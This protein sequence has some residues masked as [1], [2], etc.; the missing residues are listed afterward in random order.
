MDV[1]STENQKYPK[2]GKKKYIKK[3][4]MNSNEIVFFEKLK[5]GLIGLHVFPQVSMNQVLDV[6]Q[7]KDYK[8]RIPFWAK[9]ID[10]VICTPQCQVL[11]IIELDGPS[12]DTPEQK[13]KDKDR[14]AML[15]QAGYIVLRYD[16][17]VEVTEHQL[18]KDFQRIIKVWHTIKLREEF[19]KKEKQIIRALAEEH[20]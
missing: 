18:N 13:Q 17:R 14:D 2:K 15:E 10:F 7:Q 11:A 19:L 6:E 4:L 5:K 9:I 16:W 1:I 3:T 12:H 8:D 20:A